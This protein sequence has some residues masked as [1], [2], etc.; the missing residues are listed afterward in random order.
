MQALEE[1]LL[2]PTQVWGSELRNPGG[3]SFS[4]EMM[5]NIRLPY[6]VVFTLELF[7]N[8]GIAAQV[9]FD[10]FLGSGQMVSR[11]QT[12]AE[13][14]YTMHGQQIVV[15]GIVVANAAVKSIGAWCSLWPIASES[16]ASALPATVV[17][18]PSAT[19]TEFGSV[20]PGPGVGVAFTLIP[21]N[22]ARRGFV[23]ANNALSPVDIFFTGGLG[24]M[25]ELFPGDELPV[26]PFRYVGNV[27]ARWQGG[28]GG[29]VRAT[30]FT[31]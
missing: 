3:P 15:R 6:P 11:Q 26:L 1:A 18:A 10:V 28:L 21:A 27:V 13:G 7:R 25:Y 12:F 19:A 24:G 30:E 8:G 14:R 29:A 31:P 5:V 22:P 16:G 9:S 4:A 2:D 17:E 23:V 20:S